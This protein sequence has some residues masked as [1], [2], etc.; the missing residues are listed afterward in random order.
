VIEVT[1]RD[2]GGRNL[3]RIV[4]PLAG[5]L[6]VCALLAAQGLFAQS[7]ADLAGGP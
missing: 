3:N 2:L 1:S 7:A 5:L 6:A 4:K